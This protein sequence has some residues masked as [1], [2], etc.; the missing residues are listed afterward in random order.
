MGLTLK[1]ALF[2]TFTLP[3]LA[4]T[5]T[6]CE[7]LKESFNEVHELLG[8]APCQNST[9]ENCKS[10]EDHESELKSLL[11]Q[12]RLKKGIDELHQSITDQ[13][14]D[15]NLIMVRKKLENFKDHLM[16][17]LAL[18]NIFNPKD[19]NQ[20]NF[21]LIS[22]GEVNK[23]D[24]KET[25]SQKKDEMKEELK[26]FCFYFNEIKN[27]EVMDKVANFSK[28][29]AITNLE[30]KN[31]GEST[32]SKADKFKDIYMSLHKVKISSRAS[33]GELYGPNIWLNYSYFDDLTYNNF[34]QSFK[35]QDIS[36]NLKGYFEK[37]NTT[38]SD[39]ALNDDQQK[40]ISKLNADLKFLGLTDTNEITKINKC[41]I[42]GKKDE[43]TK[44]LVSLSD[45]ALD[46]EIQKKK[47]SLENLSNSL[48]SDKAYPELVKFMAAQAY[49]LKAMGED[50]KEDLMVS[51]YDS[52]DVFSK[53]LYTLGDD[54][55][56]IVDFIPQ[57]QVSLTDKD[58]KKTTVYK[59]A[60]KV[61]IKKMMCSYK[62]FKIAEKYCPKKEEITSKMSA[63]DLAY[64]EYLAGE[65]EAQKS[66][67]MQEVGA[68]IQNLLNPNQGMNQ[69]Q[70]PYYGPNWYTP[71]PVSY[72]PPSMYNPFSNLDG[73]YN[74]AGINFYRSYNGPSQYD[75]IYNPLYTPTLP[76]WSDPGF[77]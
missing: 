32:L 53:T 51:C 31:E 13:K 43:C 6:S 56:G 46:Q 10:L 52:A 21:K 20:N 62:D 74:P 36:E 27:E 67:A 69:G 8:K 48:K 42:S 9:D 12:K 37:L 26:N 35:I 2:L 65:K 11:A 64:Q 41:I 33:F 44:D 23:E 60:S 22:V 58:G 39:K 76:K 18:E 55:S 47:D 77:I 4:W 25:C 73:S 30:V 1:F 40:M 19:F 54:V 17:K 50:C 5:Q 72:S 66:A 59:N 71:N 63:S 24:I 28:D 49:F 16:L 29:L 75:M 3:N 38:T 34:E 7:D 15:P 45:K 70:N 57:T 68:V 61:D 14:N